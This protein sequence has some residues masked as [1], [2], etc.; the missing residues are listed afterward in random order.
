MLGA[1]DDG[2]MLGT[3]DDGSILGTL[4][5]GFALGVL[6]PGCIY[7]MTTF[8]FAFLSGEIVFFVIEVTQ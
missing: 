4:D 8:P 7:L 3:V 2:A 1:L 6:V 5:D